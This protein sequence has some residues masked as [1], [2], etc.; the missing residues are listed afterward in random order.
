MAAVKRPLQV[1]VGS[2]VFPA[3]GER[4]ENPVLKNVEFQV[5]PG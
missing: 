5:E 1:R 2:K 4:P 3:V